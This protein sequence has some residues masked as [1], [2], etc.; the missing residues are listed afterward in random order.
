MAGSFFEQHFEKNL[1]KIVA[2]KIE[3]KLGP[4]ANGDCREPYEYGYA[5]G[6]IAGLRFA[7][8]GCDEAK[9]LLGTN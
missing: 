7:L 6:F 4:L 9:R 2:E 1:R 8:S 3:E 5:C